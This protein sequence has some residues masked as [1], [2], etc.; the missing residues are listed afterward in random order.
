MYEIHETVW[1]I[2]EKTSQRFL[3]RIDSELPE[4]IHFSEFPL[5]A[6]MIKE[7]GEQFMEGQEI[8][9]YIGEA[10]SCFEVVEVEITYKVK[11]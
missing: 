7:N 5:A 6:F 2:K 4:G 10:V 1:A 11:V 3:Y 8:K 9:D